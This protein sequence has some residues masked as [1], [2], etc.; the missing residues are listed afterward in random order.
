VVALNKCDSLGDEEIEEKLAALRKVSPYE[1]FAISAVAGQN[2]QPC[3]HA[4]NGFITRMRHNKEEE[5]QESQPSKPWSP[6][7]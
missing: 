6:L 5:E 3:L 4:V 2:L 7:D 1:V